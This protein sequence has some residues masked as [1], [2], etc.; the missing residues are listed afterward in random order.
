MCRWFHVWIQPKDFRNHVFSP[1]A[2]GFKTKE[3]CHCWYSSLLWF[4]WDSTPD[5]SGLFLNQV[6][7]LFYSQ[8]KIEWEYIS[9]IH[10][11]GPWNFL[12]PLLFD[13]KKQKEAQRL[14]HLFVV[15]PLGFK[16]RTFRTFSQPSLSALIKSKK[17]HSVCCTSLL[18]FRWD[19]NP[20][21]SELFLNQ[22]FL[23]F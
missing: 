10:H 12:K 18:W 14:L 8:A 6:F 11:M 13:Y 22:V 20:G 5:L 4:R 17:R 23:L 9:F 2:C 1:K 3:E 16:P 19:S 21:P 15:I 7:P